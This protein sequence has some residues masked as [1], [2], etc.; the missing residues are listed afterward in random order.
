MHDYRFPQMKPSP[1]FSR[2]YKLLHDATLMSSWWRKADEIQ[3][4]E[5]H[6]RGLV[7]RWQLDEISGSGSSACSCVPN[8]EPTIWVVHKPRN[9]EIAAPEP[10]RKLMQ[11]SPLFS[12]F[13]FHYR[14]GPRAHHHI[15]TISEN[16]W[17]SAENLQKIFFEAQTRCLGE[18]RKAE[19]KTRQKENTK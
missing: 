11:K 15:L 14:K 4:N 18:G 9:S 6:P 7:S 16:I 2:R 3:R 1:T 12:F 19:E 5:K 13:F 10:S 17:H 8:S